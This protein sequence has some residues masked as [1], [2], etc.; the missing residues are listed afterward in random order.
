MNSQLYWAKLSTRIFISEWTGE[1]EYM[2]RCQTWTKRLLNGSCYGYI[3][4]YGWERGILLRTHVGT[5]VVYSGLIHWWWR[6]GH[7]ICLVSESMLIYVW[8]VA[9]AVKA[10]FKL[11]SWH[12]VPFE[13]S[14]AEVFHRK[15]GRD[16]SARHVAWKC[17][18]M[19]F[20]NRRGRLGHMPCDGYFHCS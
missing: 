6:H 3:S 10:V 18:G 9:W 13:L 5:Q 19:V 1:T 15:G 8:G 20:R 4:N 14:V 7:N 16:I 2:A 12:A 11:P 17:Q